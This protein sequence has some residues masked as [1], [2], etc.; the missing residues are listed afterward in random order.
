MIDIFVKDLSFSALLDTYGPVLS[1]KKQQILGYYY[2]DDYS[3]SEISELTGISR[4]GVRDC[5]KKGEEELRRLEADLGILEAERENRRTVAA[6]ISEIETVKNE[7]G[8]PQLSEAL[9]GI[10]KKLQPLV[11]EE[12]IED[13]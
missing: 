3:L 10:L 7:R 1:E 2:N 12:S 9:D 11:A 4:Q 13:F 8:D 6:V 5:I